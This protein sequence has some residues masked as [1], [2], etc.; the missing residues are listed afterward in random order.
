VI[1]ALVAGACTDGGRAREITDALVPASTVAAF[2]VEANAVVEDVVDGD[3]IDV[4]VEGRDD[5]VRLIGI[6]TPET[7]RPDTP[8]ECFGPE[9]TDFVSR[10]LPAG[11]PV[12]LERDVVGRDDYG[13][14]LAYVFVA[15]DGTF[16][17]HE[18][19]R[20]GYAEPLSIP[21][22]VAY[23]DLFVDAA[24]AAEADDLGLWS[25]CGER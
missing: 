1:G 6:D 16:V 24:R 21:P 15:A 11:T 4:R 23:S 20:R 10:L 12:R 13:R 8:V 14:L 9:A 22:N 18:I 5:R 2:P 7:K 17:N 3:T 25:A 19:V